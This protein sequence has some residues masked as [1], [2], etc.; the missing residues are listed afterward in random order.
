MKRKNAYIKS[1]TTTSHLLQRACWWGGMM[2][3]EAG[4]T[5]RRPAR[6][7]LGI[8][9]M[10]RRKLDGAR[11]QRREER[12]GENYFRHGDGKKWVP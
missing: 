2:T 7:V 10:V 1:K 6:E 9:D 5:Y 12:S 4:Q 3:M 8:L 11:I